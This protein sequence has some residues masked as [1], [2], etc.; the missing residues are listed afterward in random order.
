VYFEVAT[1]RL[2]AVRY[3]VNRELVEHRGE[4][5]KYQFKSVYNEDLIDAK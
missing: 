3:Q 4:G 5:S 2:R 1:G